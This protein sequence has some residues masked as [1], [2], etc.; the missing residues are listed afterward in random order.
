MEICIGKR[1]GTTYDMRYSHLGFGCSP[2]GRRDSWIA[3]APRLT[4]CQVCEMVAAAAKEPAYDSSMEDL[5]HPQW[6]KVVEPIVVPKGE[7]GQPLWN[8]IYA[9][10]VCA[11]RE[12]PPGGFKDRL[13]GRELIRVAEA[14]AKAAQVTAAAAAH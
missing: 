5:K 13:W 3:G 7:N 14:K 1:N 9:D 2:E 10:H 6:G 12:T 8:H 4:Y 11:P